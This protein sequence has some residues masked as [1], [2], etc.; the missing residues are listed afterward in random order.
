MQQ[1]LSS[2]A[3]VPTS[4][5]NLNQPHPDSRSGLNPSRVSHDSMS[6][7][8]KPH[9]LRAKFVKLMQPSYLDRFNPLINHS[10]IHSLLL[11]SDGSS[12]GQTHSTNPNMFLQGNAGGVGNNPT[13]RGQGRDAEDEV[14]D[15]SSATHL[16]QGRGGGATTAVVGEVPQELIARL[17]LDDDSAALVNQLRMVPAHEQWIVSIA[18]LVAN[19]TRAQLIRAELPSPR[20]IAAAGTAEPGNGP[21]NYT[22]TIRIRDLLTVGNVEAY[23]RTHTTGGLPIAS[24]PLLLLTQHLAAQS[25]EFKEDYLPAG[26]P[27]DEAANH[28]VLGLLRSLVKHE[29]GS[30]RNLLLT[31]VKEFNCRAIE[32]PV[33][34]LGDLILVIDRIMGSRDS[35]SPAQEIRDAYTATMKVRLAFIRLEVLH[36]YLNPDPATNLSQWDIIDRKLEFLR[37][38]SLHYKQAYAR[39]I[40]KIDRELFGPHEFAD[41][42]KEAISLPSDDQ[43]QAEMAAA[44]AMALDHAAGDQPTFDSN[45]VV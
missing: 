25:D 37:R 44:S 13:E 16:I 30:L 19:L 1:P 40:I 7:L 17:S 28:S 18:L 3:H 45:V 12:L 20:E 5:G 27:D 31:N 23:S 41:I 43:V 4:V 38:Q 36:H 33:P 14:M 29:R 39:L 42:P 22:Q 6:N 10:R 11:H 34:K 24:T 9:P 15:T 21:F 32:G 8:L 26:W 35:L 2:L